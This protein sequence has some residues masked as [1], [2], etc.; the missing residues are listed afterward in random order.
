[1]TDN[2]IQLDSGGSYLFVGNSFTFGRVD[3]VMSYNTDNVRDLTA[4]V[5]GTTFANTTGSSL[6]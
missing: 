4:P 2:S 1:M 6:P 5:P 3:P